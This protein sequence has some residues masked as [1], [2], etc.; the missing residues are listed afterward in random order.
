[1]TTPTKETCQFWLM[2]SEP[3]VFSWDDLVKAKNQISAWDGVRNYQARNYM[4]QMAIGDELF[5]YHSSCKIPGI[6]GIAKIVRTAYPDSTAFDFNSDY[7]DPKSTIEN[8]RWVMV[9]VQAVRKFKQIISL[10]ELQNHKE[11][12]NKFPLLNR[13]NRLSV[14]PVSEQNWQYI[15]TLW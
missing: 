15:L 3:D 7:F 11:K 13:G 12:L 14:M 10:S 4:R 8:P 2:K 9:D 1:M 5:F 6:V